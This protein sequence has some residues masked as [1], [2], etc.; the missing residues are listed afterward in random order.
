MATVE[1]IQPLQEVGEWPTRLLPQQQFDG[2]VKQAMDQ[3]STMT[4]QL[5]EDFIPKVNSINTRAQSNADA[6]LQAKTAA[7]A[8]ATSAQTYQEQAKT[9]EGIASNAASRASVSATIAQSNAAQTAID[10]KTAKD[11]AEKAVTV[12]GV[13]IATKDSFGICRPDN[14]TVTIE[15]GVLSVI[16]GAGG[17]GLVSTPVFSGIGSAANKDTPLTFTVSA[18]SNLVKPRTIERFIY[19]IQELGIVE[20][21]VTAKNDQATITAQIPTS[22]LVGTILNIRAIAV[23]SDGAQSDVA[24]HQVTL[25]TAIVLPPKVILP[26]ANGQV[27]RTSCTIATSAFVVQSFSG[28]AGAVDTHIATQYRIRNMA[29]EI[30]YDS[31]ESANLI[32]ITITDLPANLPTEVNYTFEARHKGSSLGW[33]GWSDPVTARILSKPP[34]SRKMEFLDPGNFVF[35]VPADVT[36]VRV[37]VV[38]GGGIGE[39][40]QPGQ[41]AGTVPYVTGVADHLQN[42]KEGGAGGKGGKGGGIVSAIINVVPGASIP[43]KVGGLAQSSSFGSYLQASAGSTTA[44][45]SAVAYLG[46]NDEL[47]CNLAETPAGKYCRSLA[48][49]SQNIWHSE[50]IITAPDYAAS[51]GGDGEAGNPTVSSALATGGSLPSGSNGGAGGNG[52]ASTGWS[53]TK[54][55]KA[56]NGGN[57]GNGANNGGNGGTGGD[58]LSGA[59][60]GNGGNGGNGENNGGN[61]GA[62]GNA[63]AANVSSYCRGGI[64]GDGGNGG[65]GKGNRGGNG[66]NGGTGNT[67]LYRL[68]GAT[69]RNIGGNGGDGG[70]GLITGGNG[71]SGGRDDTSPDGNPYDTGI[72]TGGNGGNGGNGGSRGGNGGGGG[73]GGASGTTS[74][75]RHG[76]KGGNGGQGA[77]GGDGGDGGIGGWVARYRA[78]PGTGGDAGNGGDG[79]AYGGCG[80]NGGVGGRGGNDTTAERIYASGKPGLSG[81]GGDGGIGGNGGDGGKGGYSGWGR[82]S[83]SAG[84][85]GG[86][87][88]NGGK[89]CVA[90]YY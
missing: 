74:G 71:G 42:G 25:Q 43:I 7:Q 59:T 64:G 40:G 68:Y 4:R 26:A 89:G 35:S 10:A 86:T 79:W 62:G 47:I 65:T 1:Q 14:K 15:G 87:G 58:G 6:A 30:I 8:S 67:Y 51:I 23:D 37:L 78:A 9:S 11:A 63:Q 34:F 80:G 82:K 13:D 75:Y 24:T 28:G 70:V 45:G 90:I 53:T 69:K 84:G 55:G 66:G 27:L 83:C 46:P 16:G 60:A 36:Q 41:A 54:V 21:V 85:K 49:M 19:S 52:G 56:G 44:R 12:S 72:T 50:L 48:N 17:K 33:S 22:M 32:R 38:G 76:G 73:R 77:I 20:Q 29:N 81:K 3:M 31:G 88:G 18:S 57:G 61:G 39:D 2:R 5:N